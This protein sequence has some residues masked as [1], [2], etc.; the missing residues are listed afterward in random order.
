AAG[1]NI[2][3]WSV[4]LAWRAKNGPPKP[5]DVPASEW[6]KM[7]AVEYEDFLQKGLGGKPSTPANRR[8]VMEPLVRWYRSNL[9]ATIARTKQKGQMKR[10]IGRVLQGFLKM[11]KEAFELYDLHVFGYIMHLVPDKAGDTYSRSWGSTPAYEQMLLDHKPLINRE[12]HKYESMM[13]VSQ[14]SLDN[15]ERYIV[16]DIDDEESRKRDKLCT[17]FNNQIRQDIGRILFSRGKV[18]LQDALDWKIQWARWPKQAVEEKLRLINW[19]V[20][21]ALPTELGNDAPRQIKGELMRHSI[22][23]R[24]EVYPNFAIEGDRSTIDYV[25]IVS[26]TNEERDL[27][28]YDD[29]WGSIPI[30]V[31]DAGKVL[32]TA[33]HSKT[34]KFNRK[35]KASQKKKGKAKETSN[36]VSDG[37]DDVDNETESRPSPGSSKSKRKDKGKK[38][39]LEDSESDG[40]SVDLPQKRARVPSVPS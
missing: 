34:I 16:Q 23:A 29:A 11:S 35:S 14:L 21:H 6:P 2:S 10:V 33:V 25:A 7:L 36:D 38:R 18:P 31:D 13:T 9:L 37:S 32:L 5:A 12:I 24:H 8:A 19:P 30:L 27:L 22:Q 15:I 17:I 4:F 28:E 40:D 39:R 20:G 3:I 1:R 26:W